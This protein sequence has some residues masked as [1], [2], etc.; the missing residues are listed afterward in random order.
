[1]SLGARGN[2]ANGIRLRIFW[3][4]GGLMP[5]FALDRNGFHLSLKILQ[6]QLLCQGIH[7]VIIIPSTAIDAF[8]L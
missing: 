7:G 5:S 2:F 6:A 4:V 1:M 8:S 3:P